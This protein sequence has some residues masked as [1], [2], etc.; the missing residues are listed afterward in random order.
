MDDNETSPELSLDCGGEALSSWRM[1]MMLVMMI[2][3][4]IMMMVMVIVMTMIMI[5]MLVVVI[6]MMMMVTNWEGE[7]LPLPGEE[8]LSPIVAII[9]CL[10]QQV[11][12][13]GFYN[14]T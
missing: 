3:M 7:Q 10:L 5:M 6:V 4:M 8:S 11:F 12:V 14:R 2:I 13:H 1:I 9:S